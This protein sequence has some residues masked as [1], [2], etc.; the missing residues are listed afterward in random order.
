MKSSLDSINSTYQL[1]IK[2]DDP[3]NEE[4]Q[5]E[6]FCTICSNSM[7]GVFELNRD[8]FENN[9]EVKNPIGIIKLKCGHIYHKLC[10]SQWLSTK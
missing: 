5:N 2:K 3:I 6:T 1:D 4:I 8:N 7:A 9:F 10:L